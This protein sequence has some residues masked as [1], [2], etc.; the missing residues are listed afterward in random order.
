MADT[1]EFFKYEALQH[2]NIRLFELL[3][4]ANGQ[5]IRGTFHITSITPSTVELYSALSYTWGT[6]TPEKP[7]LLLDGH[8]LEVRKNLYEA[9]EQLRWTDHPRRLWIDAIC[10]NQK[11]DTEKDKQL[12]LMSEIYSKAET[13]EIWLGPTEDNSDIALRA[14]TG[15]KFSVQEALTVLP[16][17]GALIQR[18][19]FMRVWIIQEVGLAAPG[20][21]FIN[22]GSLR[23][24][25]DTFLTGIKRTVCNI[26]TIFEESQT[27]DLNDVK[28]AV[29]RNELSNKMNSFGL[30][31]DALCNTRTLLL[32]YRASYEE[33]ISLKTERMVGSFLRNSRHAEATKPEDKVFGLCGCYAPAAMS[34]LMASKHKPL[35]EIYFATT[36]YILQ[37]DPLP[38]IYHSFPILPLSKLQGDWCP[39]LDSGFVV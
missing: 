17:L 13:A 8:R 36:L 4:G 5:P 2:G 3:P 15:E 1:L 6:D 18:P 27:L 35:E 22:C 34:V 37:N 30:N 28:L 32:N 14:L 16:A 12:P 29:L 20:A 38:N 10:I 33:D 23:I 26:D 9:L 25:W 19:W 7:T 39:I 11:N 31:I 21:A 24:D